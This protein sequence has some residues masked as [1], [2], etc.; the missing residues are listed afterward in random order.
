MTKQ[1]KTYISTRKYFVTVYSQK[2]SSLLK[3]TKKQ[4]TIY[5]NITNLQK[6]KKN[7]KKTKQKTQDI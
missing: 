7:K 4:H 1:K 6:V 5:F 2:L 3:H